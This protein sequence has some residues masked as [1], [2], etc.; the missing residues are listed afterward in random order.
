MNN[1]SIIYVENDSYYLFDGTALVECK[2]SLAKK[3]FVGATLSLSDF[4]IG[5]FKQPASLSADAL[6]IQNEIK[7]HEEGGLRAELNYEIVSVDHLL[8][9][10]NSYLVEAFAIATDDLKQHF[11]PILKKTK[12]IDL[13][14]PSFLAYEA[15][16]VSGQLE[17]KDDLFFYL[18]D[19]IAYAVIFQDGKYIAHRRIASIDQIAK[20]SGLE[21]LEC[22]E[23]LHAKGV[24]AKNY[25][26]DR[27][28]EFE[29]LELVFSKQIEKVV[30][31]INHKRGLF[32]LNG[33]ERIVVDFNGALLEGIGEIFQ[34]YGMQDVVVEPLQCLDSDAVSAHRY[35][36]ALYIYLALKEKIEPLNISIFQREPLFITRPSGKLAMVL[37]SGTLLALVY[38]LYHLFS[39]LQIDEKITSI[40]RE[41]TSTQLQ[42]QQLQ[43][44]LLSAKDRSKKMETQLFELQKINQRYSQTLQ[45]LPILTESNYI[46]QKMMNDVVSILGAYKLSTLSIEQNGTKSMKLHLIADYRARENIAKF[47]RR[48]MESGYKEART[49]E[50]YLDENVYESIIEVI[51]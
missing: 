32:G 17:K 37:V 6:E 29:K 9:F 47:M 5:S 51:R 31:T 19:H 23:M 24:R 2:P 48:W 10:E 4:I 42:K 34:A 28:A 8:D 36:Q 40:N 21:A 1:S 7:M 16:Y 35:C 50:I 46:R 27:R 15:L 30:H 41:L 12:V 20:E 13:I 11:N 25:S 33:I 44:R 39:I 45:T 18:D 43:K 49:E 38:P 3:Y 14:F 26:E 22:K